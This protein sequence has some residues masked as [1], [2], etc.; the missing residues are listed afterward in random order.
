MKR[1]LAH[2]DVSEYALPALLTVLVTVVGRL[3][4]GTLAAS[5]GKFKGNPFSN[6]IFKSCKCSQL[7]KFMNGL[8]FLCVA[9]AWIA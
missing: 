6:N 7:Q 9:F 2:G 4:K 3:A 1:A 5:A 8:K